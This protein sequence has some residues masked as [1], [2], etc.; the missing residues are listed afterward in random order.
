VIVMKFGGTSVGSRE[1]LQRMARLVAED[2]R[3]KVVVVS[4]MA[5]TTDRLLDAGRA[6]E[7]GDR[8][9]L[10][11]VLSGIGALARSATDEPVPAT[12]R[13]IAELTGLL[14]GV[15][16]LRE[17]TARSRALLASFGERLAIGVASAH[18]RALG[19][20]ARPVDAREIVR[21]DATFEEGKVDVSVTRALCRARLLPVCAGGVVPVV[22]GFIGATPERRDHPARSRR[23]RTASGALFGAFLDA[24]VIEIWTDV[25]GILSADPRVVRDARAAAGGELPRS[26]GDVVLRREGGPPEDDAAGPRAR[27]PHRHPQHV[28]AGASRARGSAE[29][30]RPSRSG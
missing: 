27:H 6:A 30:P 22:T 29:R 28:Q 19:V 18:L 1:R 14:D 15:V 10:A 9:R 4:A 8:A 23:A 12:D 13:L 3:P 25:D 20:D 2:P 17:Q 11:Q 24:D 7:R 26:G 5:D 21:T 16:L